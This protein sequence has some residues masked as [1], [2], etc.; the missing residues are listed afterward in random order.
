MLPKTQTACRH[1]CR[2]VEKFQ[3]SNIIS[4]YGTHT[5]CCV[6]L[7]NCYVK[8]LGG[9]LCKNQ[10]LHFQKN[11]LQIKESIWLLPFL[12]SSGV[13]T[14][15][16]IHHKI[17]GLHRDKYT[18]KPYI[19]NILQGTESGLYH[20]LLLSTSLRGRLGWKSG[21]GP[22]SLK[23]LPWQSEDSN[24]GLPDN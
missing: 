24:L 4:L 17:C 11:N 16:N 10:I 19:C 22:R 18:T 13:L 8:W 7:R 20:S 23:K 12:W 5:Y 6:L 14:P 15:V 3:D 9:W 2:A 21:T 1:C